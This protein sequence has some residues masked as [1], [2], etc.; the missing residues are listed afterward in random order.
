MK[1]IFLWVVGPGTPHPYVGTENIVG[2]GGPK[3]VT[4]CGLKNR[5][6]DKFMG[7]GVGRV[8]ELLKKRQKSNFFGK[9]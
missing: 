2:R 9:H 1:K 8:G 6:G 4:G 3:I 5:E 7:Q